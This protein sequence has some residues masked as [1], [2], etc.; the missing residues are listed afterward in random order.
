MGAEV[1]ADLRV[2]KAVLVASGERNDN[3]RIVRN[4][5]PVEVGKA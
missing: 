3:V 2:S 1:K 4:E 5:T